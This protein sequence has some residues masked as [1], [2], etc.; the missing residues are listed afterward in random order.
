M[1]YLNASPGKEGDPGGAVAWVTR[2]TLGEVLDRV[3]KWIPGMTDPTQLEWSGFIEFTL[4]KRIAGV[5][6]TICNDNNDVVQRF[7]NI[8]LGKN[9]DKDNMK[10]AAAIVWNQLLAKFLSVLLS[11]GSARKKPLDSNIC[12]I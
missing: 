12:K 5:H 1:T 2:D 6:H 7:E 10:I 3:S 8:S 11:S 9:I 4:M